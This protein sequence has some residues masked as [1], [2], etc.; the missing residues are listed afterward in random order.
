MKRLLWLSAMLGVAIFLGAPSAAIAEE[1]IGVIL[2]HG[3]DGTVNSQSPVGKLAS[4]LRGDFKVKALTMPWSRQNK[5]NGTLEDA[6]KKIDQAVAQLRKAGATK[7]VVGGHSMGAA[8]A[9]AYATQTTGLGGVLMIAA[10]HRP[11][12]YA[13]KNTNA[14]ANARAFIAAGNPAGKVKIFDKNQGKRIARSL[15]ADVAVSWFDPASLAIMQNAAPRV[16]PGTPVLFIIGDHDGLHP[17]GKSLIFEKLPQHPKNAYTV[18]RGGHKAT[19]T[20]G[21]SEITAWLR[22]L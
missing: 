11:D 15:D 9:L 12:L 21:K 10:G 13:G 17:G 3:K 22:A 20:I 7:V 14:I 8:A 19:P 1:K 16:Q 4:Y 2:M 5:F 6:F 18:V